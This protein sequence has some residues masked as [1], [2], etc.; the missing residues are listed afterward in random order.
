[1][2]G[3]E[4]ESGDA[5]LERFDLAD[6]A[7]DHPRDLSSGERQRLAIA[8]VAVMRPR[9]LILDEPTRGVDGLRK[10]AVVELMRGLSEDGTAAV[11]V[12]H[13]MDF[14]AEVA[15][16]VTTMAAE[17]AARRGRAAPGQPPVLRVAGRARVWLRV[18][19]RGGRPAAAEQ[20]A[21]N[22]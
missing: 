12:T 5:E 4:L 2:S 18:G 14:A 22:A 7:G 21:V 3:A 13:D 9:L 8:S 15:D 16:T 1:M 20:V 10:L 11:V 17:G 6:R 19:R